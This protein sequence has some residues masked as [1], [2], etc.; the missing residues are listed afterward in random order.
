MHASTSSRPQE[1]TEH[2]LAAALDHHPADREAFLAR[3]CGD[4][5]ALLAEVQGLMAAHEAMPG[6]FLDKWA[7]AHLVLGGSGAGKAPGTGK[8]GGSKKIQHLM[9]LLL[10]RLRMR[11]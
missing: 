9:S 6:Q 3:A 10:A 2:I 5:H 1:A 11:G 8:K 4:D 7:A